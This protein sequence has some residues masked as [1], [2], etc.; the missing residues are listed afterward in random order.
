MDDRQ[1]VPA[2]LLRAR[3]TGWAFAT[4]PLW[5]LA[6]WVILWPLGGRSGPGTAWN[7]AHLGWLVGFACLALVCGELRRRALERSRDQARAVNVVAGLTLAGLALSSAQMV[8]DLVAG[9]DALNYDDMQARA[10]AITQGLGLDL[11]FST[12]GPPLVF[13]GLAGLLTMVARR[14]GV[15]PLGPVLMVSA[16]VVIAVDEDLTPIALA[17][18]LLALAPTGWRMLREHPRIRLAV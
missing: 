13:I 2:A 9:L 11:L 12:V 4:A 3:A 8:V 10:A 1:A 5:L 15:S 18:M 14:R 7:L 16:F 6:A 17:L